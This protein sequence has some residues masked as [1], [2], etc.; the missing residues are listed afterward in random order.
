MFTE[1]D[2]GA[3]SGTNLL[4]QVTYFLLLPN[5]MIFL[6][7]LLYSI[8]ICTLYVYCYVLL[9][10]CCWKSVSVLKIVSTL[11]GKVSKSCSFPDTF[12]YCVR[13]VAQCSV[14]PL[15][16]LRHNVCVMSACVFGSLIQQSEL[17][18]LQLER[19][20]T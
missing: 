6:C 5:S 18:D 11:H 17:H 13:P 15:R 16:T 2:T 1:T 9:S 10:V 8:I 7:V 14:C 19:L 20:L 3:P 12:D 4:L